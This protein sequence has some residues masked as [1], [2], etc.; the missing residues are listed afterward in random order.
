MSCNFS[1][2]A[3]LGCVTVSISSGISLNLCP[4]H[5]ESDLF[6]DP[7]EPVHITILNEKH[8]TRNDASGPVVKTIWS[9]LMD[10]S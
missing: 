1:L 7:T 6:K 10:L 3:A 8:T 2:T 4:N 9:E 5:S